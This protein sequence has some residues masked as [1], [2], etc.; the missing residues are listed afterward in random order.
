MLL[1]LSEMRWMRWQPLSSR[2]RR[3]KINLA[4]L[5]RQLKLQR[6]THLN[7]RSINPHV[8]C[9]A[10]PFP[11]GPCPKRVRDYILQK[12]SPLI[13]KLGQLA[14]V[15]E[16]LLRTMFAKLFGVKA[17][18]LICTMY[19]CLISVLSKLDY[20]SLNPS[21]VA[22]RCGPPLTRPRGNIG[23]WWAEAT[24]DHVQCV[25]CGLS[26]VSTGHVIWILASDWSLIESRGNVTCKAAPLIAATSK[27]INRET[28]PGQVKC[29]H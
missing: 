24:C 11:T 1:V 19:I 26:L 27:F 22:Q 8:F 20:K 25:I 28:M 17:P 4:T 7:P 14:I 6:E 29:S 10:Q 12:I 5:R 3:K 18:C 13:T 15:W 16:L 9:V 23:V 21:V 2:R